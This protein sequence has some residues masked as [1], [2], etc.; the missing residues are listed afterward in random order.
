MVGSTVGW[1][2]GVG[3]RA[4]AV[5]TSKGR[6]NC[7]WQLAIGLS[8]RFDSATRARL[9]IGRQP[10]T[11]QRAR[12]R[13]RGCGERVYAAVANKSRV[14]GHVQERVEGGSCVVVERIPG[15]LCWITNCIRQGSL[16]VLSAVC[17][18]PIGLSH[19]LAGCGRRACN[20][21]SHTL[22]IHPRPQTLFIKILRSHVERKWHGACFKQLHQCQ[23]GESPARVP[24]PAPLSPLYLCLSNSF[25]HCVSQRGIEVIQQL[26]W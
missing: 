13:A 22:P 17:A 7:I 15:V 8:A 2:G 23:S 14:Y 19:V 16:P 3:S 18:L 1:E 10:G 9:Q 21:P 11:G 20:L 4:E 12:A 24:L 25:S 26:H 6:I 5:A